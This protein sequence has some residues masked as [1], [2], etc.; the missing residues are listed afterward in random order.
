MAKKISERQKLPSFNKASRKRYLRN[1]LCEMKSEMTGSQ[2]LF[3]IVFKFNDMTHGFEC[4]FSIVPRKNTD[5]KVPNVISLHNDMEFFVE[6]M[7]D[8]MFSNK[9]EVNWSTNKKSLK[10]KFTIRSY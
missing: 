4:E 6:D 10:T 8:Y 2:N 9:V 3:D 5:V 1:V 7:L